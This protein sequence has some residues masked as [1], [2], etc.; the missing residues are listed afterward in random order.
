MAECLVPCV[1]NLVEVIGPD[2]KPLLSAGID[3]LIAAGGG[4]AIGGFDSC[5]AAIERGLIL[6]MLNLGEKSAA[7]C[8]EAL[9]HFYGDNTSEA[10]TK[11]NAKGWR[12]FANDAEA[13][14]GAACDVVEDARAAAGI[15]AG[16]DFFPGSDFKDW[17][18]DIIDQE[19]NPTPGEGMN[20]KVNDMVNA[21]DSVLGDALA[22]KFKA[23]GNWMRLC[24]DVTDANGTGVANAE[25]K[26][27]LEI[28]TLDDFAQDIFD[29]LIGP[30]ID[31]YIDLVDCKEQL[32]SE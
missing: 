24:G 27:C 28:V 8:A 7:E 30:A 26:L 18:Q 11:A 29:E 10:V 4:I 32:A 15:P 31:R 2:G 20:D 12:D 23:T 9:C 21:I 13:I 16:E 6:L 1:C 22:N 25:K 14:L 19:F 3:T 17:L 5:E